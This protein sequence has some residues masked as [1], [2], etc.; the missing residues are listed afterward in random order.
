[1]LVVVVVVYSS[2]CITVPK[3]S[4]GQIHPKVQY[5]WDIFVPLKRKQR[6]K[7]KRFFEF[8]KNLTNNIQLLSFE[9]NLHCAL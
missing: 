4:L 8:N 2:S 9:Q 5:R 6:K 3:R 1:M 7:L